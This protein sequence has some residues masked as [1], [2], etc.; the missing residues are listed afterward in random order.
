MCG[1]TFGKKHNFCRPLFLPSPFAHQPLPS[2]LCHLANDSSEALP[3]PCII[4]PELQRGNME[5]NWSNWAKFSI[6]HR[7]VGR[8]KERSAIQKQRIK[9]KN[10]PQMAERQ[11][12]EVGINLRGAESP[13]YCAAL[14]RWETCTNAGHKL[15]SPVC[16]SW[17][18]TLKKRSKH[19][20][21]LRKMNLLH[22][23]TQQVIFPHI[24]TSSILP[25]HGALVLRQFLVFLGDFTFSSTP[26]FGWWGANIILLIHQ[27]ILLICKWQKEWVTFSFVTFAIKA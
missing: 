17:S 13:F 9:K 18:R 6:Q 22:L 7:Q 4:Y 25:L 15:E 21:S 12:A 26:G 19:W 24:R 16:T 2:H 27:S 14:I 5:G 11:L 1:K 8:Q 23:L 3:L 20:H 10:V